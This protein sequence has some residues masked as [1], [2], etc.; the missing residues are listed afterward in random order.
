MKKFTKLLILVVIIL[1]FQSFGNQTQNEQLEKS[2]VEASDSLI[3]N[4]I[5]KMS[6]EQKVG[7]MTQINIDVIS[8]GKIYN[9]EVPH[10]IDSAKLDI[11][12][13]KYFVGSIL[14]AAGYPFSRD[15]WKNIITT[16]WTLSVKIEALKPP[17]NV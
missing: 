8:K 3:D 6:I 17:Y 13:N 7:Q 1:N 2:N 16:I 11:A 5:K 9:L 12:I 4:L 15:Q 14:N 10:Q